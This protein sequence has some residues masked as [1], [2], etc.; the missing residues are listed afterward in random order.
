MYDSNMFVSLRSHAAVKTVLA[1]LFPQKLL[2]VAGSFGVDH[3][4]AAVVLRELH[5][6]ANGGF[7]I[8]SEEEKE[9]DC[10]MGI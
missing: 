2:L 8:T 4:E 10:D 5:G 3:A 7:E 1:N 9:V 6:L